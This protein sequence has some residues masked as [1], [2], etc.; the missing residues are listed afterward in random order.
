MAVRSRVLKQV[1]TVVFCLGLVSC[2]SIGLPE[3]NVFPDQQDDYKRSHEIPALEVPP[4][5]QHDSSKDEYD[6]AAR[7][8]EPLVASQAVTTTYALD[9][10]MAKVELVES[11]GV[12]YLLLRDSMRNAWRMTVSGLYALEYE[13]E[14]KN[15]IDGMI[16]LEI[17]DNSDTGMLSSLSFWGSAETTPYLL[18]LKRTEQGV[19]IQVLAENE[20]VA[21]DDVS[22]LLYADLLDY[23]AK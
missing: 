4:E 12:P 23:L 21:K 1:S 5:M 15:R 14:D 19:A 18:S 11:E 8:T 10:S 16:Y 6:G 9:D 13:I 7:G 20:E 17:A 2:S 22:E 3:M